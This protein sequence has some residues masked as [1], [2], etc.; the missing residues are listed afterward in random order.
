[1]NCSEHTLCSLVALWFDGG[2]IS[3]ITTRKRSNPSWHS[4][5][6]PCIGSCNASYTVESGLSA[7]Q[8]FH[9]ERMIPLLQHLVFKHFGFEQLANIILWAWQSGSALSACIGTC[10]FHRWPCLS[11]VSILA[12]W[13]V[14]ISVAFFGFRKERVSALHSISVH[15]LS[16][17]IIG[18]IF[19]SDLFRMI[20]HL[21]PTPSGAF[22]NYLA[23]SLCS[24]GWTPHRISCT[25]SGWVLKPQTLCHRLTHSLIHFGDSI[26][27]TTTMSLHLFLFD[28]HYGERSYLDSEFVLDS[29]SLKV[30]WSMKIFQEHSRNFWN[31][32]KF[33]FW[34]YRLNVTLFP[35]L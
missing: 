3:S 30:W 14:L 4:P 19:L 9:D 25:A 2:F 17:S 24:C 34:I 13:S 21:L 26:P 18:F 12:V 6:S 7:Q 5:K 29:E 8:H 28:E 31:S 23:L 1:M 22:S 27:F 32:T 33:M 16:F 20:G 10:G 15:K 11:L 35:M